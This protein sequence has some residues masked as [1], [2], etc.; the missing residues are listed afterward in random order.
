M[1]PDFESLLRVNLTKSNVRISIQM[2]VMHFKIE[3]TN[4]RQNHCLVNFFQKHFVKSSYSKAVGNLS[5]QALMI[6]RL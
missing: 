5:E 2:N 1:T 6:T 3:I 4:L